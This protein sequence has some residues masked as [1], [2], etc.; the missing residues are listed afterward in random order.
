MII[1]DIMIYS[2]IILGL[3]ILLIRFRKLRKLFWVDFVL[4]A[5]IIAFGTYLIV[6]Q[7][8]SYSKKN[9]MKKGFDIIS[10]VVEHNKADTLKTDLEKLKLFVQTLEEID[11]SDTPDDF[12]EAFKNYRYE[13]R[14]TRNKSIEQG[15]IYLGNDDQIKKASEILMN[16]YSKC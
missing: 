5:I 16:I 8:D 10:K 14:K 11:L 4:I 7:A 6:L 9:K 15:E 1:T 2:V 3:L 12:R 13:F